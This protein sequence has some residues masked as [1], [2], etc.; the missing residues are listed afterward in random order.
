MLVTGFGD[1]LNKNYRELE[2]DFATLAKRRLHPLIT[3]KTQIL[4]RSC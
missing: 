2:R 4:H 1:A 3:P